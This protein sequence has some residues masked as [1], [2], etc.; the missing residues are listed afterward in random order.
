[1]PRKLQAL[2]SASRYGRPNERLPLDRAERELPAGIGW[3]G[4][5]ILLQFVGELQK[6]PRLAAVAHRAGEA[7]KG[8]QVALGRAPA[9]LEVAEPPFH[10]IPVGVDLGDRAP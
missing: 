6:P 10:Q 4:G 1:M 5:A 3:T 7:R 8:V 2:F 9:R